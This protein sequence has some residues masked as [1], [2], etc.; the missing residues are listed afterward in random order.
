[1]AA[2]CVSFRKNKK[3]FD[4]LSVFLTKKNSI[5][6]KISIYEGS[7]LDKN[8]FNKPNCVIILTIFRK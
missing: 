2:I 8:G 7:K 5:F 1:M 6:F 4:S 3:F